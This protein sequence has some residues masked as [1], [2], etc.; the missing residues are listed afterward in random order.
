MEK[1]ILLESS[2]SKFSVNVPNKMDIELDGKFKLLQDDG[3]K[4]NFSLLEQYNAER[5]AC[6]RYRMI[7]AVNPVCTNA[8]FN[9]QS[10]IVK[11][12]GSD[13]PI[14]LTEAKIDPSAITKA[15]GSSGNSIVNTSL[16]NRYQAIKDTEYSHPENG[17]FVYH[18]G[19][20]IFNNHMLR[21]DGFVHVNKIGANS[22]EVGE[23][24]SEQVYNTIADYLRDGNGKIVEKATNVETTER[25]KVR[26]YSMDSVLT[27]KRAYLNRLKENNG[28]LGFT[29]PGNIEIPNSDKKDKF[30]NDVLINQMLAGNKPCEFI[31][32]YPDRSL[33][34]FI[35]KYNKFRDRTEKNWDYCITYPYA[36]DVEMV[37]TVCG[38][39]G[40][41]IK[42]DFTL[43]HNPSSTN[44]LMCRSAFRHTLK[45]NSKIALYYYDGGTFKKFPVPIQVIGVGNYDGSETDRYFSIRVSDIEKIFAA[46]SNGGSFSDAYDENS[47]SRA[48]ISMPNSGTF[49]Y[50]KIAGGCECEYYF[51]KYKKLKRID[52]EGQEKPL[53]SDI[54]KLA[55]GENIYGDKLAQVVFIDDINVEGLLDHLGRPVSTVYFTVI[56]RNAGRKQWYEQLNYGSSEVEFSHCFGKLTS[57]VD[58]GPSSATPIDYNVRYLHNVD[59]NGIVTQ[60]IEIMK[61]VFGDVLANHPLPKRIED[62]ITIDMDEFYGDVVEFNV[63]EYIET[64][65]S[66]VFY[67]F[68]T[69]QREKVSKIDLYPLNYDK[70]ITD[71][72]EPNRSFRVEKVNHSRIK[73]NDEEIS[74]PSNIRPEGYFYNPHMPIKIKENS[75]SVTRVRSKL[76]NYAGLTCGISMG[77]KYTTINLKAPSSYNFL[78]WDYIAFCDEGGV[79]NGEEHIKNVVWAKITEVSGVNITL[80]V[81]G[82]PFGTS[83]EEAASALYGENRRY[84][85]YYAVESVP[86][87]AGFN[88]ATQEFVWRSFVAP[89]MMT[90]Q[91]GLY[92]TP[93]SNGRFYIEKN[94]NLYLRR[95]D[96]FGDFGLSVARHSGGFHRTNPME[97]FNVDATKLDLTQVYNFYNK[98]DYLCY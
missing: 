50:K 51:R 69:E 23:E 77:G 52:S 17:G 46:L 91:N 49:F 60:N 18:C 62:D 57:G 76:V 89:S 80:Q 36:K 48:G 73:I 58:F 42:V 26:L 54:N 84:R 32:M 97:Y 83:A 13:S 67:R 98:L 38:G 10:E 65:I 96:P 30:G 35:P 70:I 5:D 81:E 87:Y 14:V 2:R 56:K 59:L 95:Q 61:D 25:K 37:N 53:R 22:Y 33:F 85:A 79:V 8:L 78:K 39:L 41:A 72:Y 75:D 20:D 44:I 3:I 43:G 66:P 94:L 34:S 19:L 21:N 40:G 31:D 4:G 6:N 24:T 27:M 7:F 63:D 86:T 9:M 55:Y 28:W 71:D 64:E 29:N 92:D 12:E 82:M 11:D 93:F 15:D 16:I 68:N 74:I 47:Y 1:Q 90:S 45:Q 88:N